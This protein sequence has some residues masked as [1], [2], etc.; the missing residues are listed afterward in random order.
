MAFLIMLCLPNFFEPEEPSYFKVPYYPPEDLE[1]QSP[2]DY[3]QKEPEENIIGP[4]IYW[5]NL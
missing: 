1:Y 5:F 2:D 4:K 3:L